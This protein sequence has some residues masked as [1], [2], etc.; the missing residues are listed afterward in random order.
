[1]PHIIVERY[2]PTDD[3]KIKW[4]KCLLSTDLI[5]ATLSTHNDEHGSG[6][7]YLRLTQPIFPDD[8]QTIVVKGTLQGVFNKIALAHDKTYEPP[9]DVEANAAMWEKK[10]KRK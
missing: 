5:A 8:G 4:V 10:L 6:I 7:T 2:V 9:F 1:M 3:D